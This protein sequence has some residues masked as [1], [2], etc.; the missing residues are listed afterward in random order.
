MIN[1][2]L[3]QKDFRIVARQQ[4]LKKS[5]VP[6]ILFGIIFIAGLIYLVIS[7]L[8]DDKDI[9]ITSIMAV[10]V[11]VFAFIFSIVRYIQICRAYAKFG[12]IEYEVLY[13]QEKVV[14]KN[15][16]ADNETIFEKIEMKPIVLKS[17]IIFYLPNAKSLVVPR[18]DITKEFLSL[19]NF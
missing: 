18:N 11:S 3:T 5:K 1:Y 17:Y 7:L 10:V 2:T 16:T 9:L 4:L 13:N 15:L 19:F 8:H 12:E 14:I 6:L